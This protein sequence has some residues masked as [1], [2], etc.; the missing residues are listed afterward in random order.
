MKIAHEIEMGFKRGPESHT[1]HTPH[2]F[3][4]LNH[5]LMNGTAHRREKR[6]STPHSQSEN[7]EK[8]HT[9]SLL[10][11]SCILCVCVCV[12]VNHTVCRKHDW[13]N[14]Y[15]TFLVSSTSLRKYNNDGMSCQ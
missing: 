15:N 6:T 12:N 5:E 1:A 14:N 3:I 13:G 8:I 2:V 9:E 4:S 7:T 11:Q 10:T